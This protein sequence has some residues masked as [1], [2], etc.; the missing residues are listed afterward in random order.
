[1]CIMYNFDFNFIKYG[2]PIITLSSLG[3]AFNKAAVESIGSPA[4]VIVGYDETNKAIGVRPRGNDTNSPYYDFAGRVKNDWVRIGAKD[5][6]KY[7]SKVTEID[8]INKAKQF[9]P[10]YDEKTNTLIIVVDKSHLK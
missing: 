9:I 7:V 2:T 4:Q 3:I 8:F 1:M 6:M 10:D 5:F